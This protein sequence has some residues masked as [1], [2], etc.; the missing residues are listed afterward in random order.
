MKRNAVI[1]IVNAEKF[2]LLKTFDVY[3]RCL[4][5]SFGKKTIGSNSFGNATKY[6]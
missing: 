4:L 1:I 3:N 2:N 6:F 5:Y